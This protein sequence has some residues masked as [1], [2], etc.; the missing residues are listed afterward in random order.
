MISGVLLAAGSDS[1]FGSHKLLHLLPGNT[2]IGVAAARHLNQGVGHASAVVK[3]DDFRLQ[4]L[5]YAEGLDIVISDHADH[6]I[7]ASLV[8]GIQ[9]TPDADSWLIALADMPWVRPQTI[10]AIAMM[11][12][13]GSSLAAPF[14]QGR[15]GHPVGFSRGLLPELPSLV[16]D[17]GA[18]ALLQTKGDLLRSYH[19]DDPGILLDIDTQAD[20]PA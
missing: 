20:L 11:L 6:G 18:C 10:H 12:Q 4:D 1:R 5:L 3:P 8:S 19:C 17:K 15:R 7:S 16:G 2:P 14:Y 13:D 9:A